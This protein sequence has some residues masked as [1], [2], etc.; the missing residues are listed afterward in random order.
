[1]IY[2]PKC[3][4]LWYILNTPR[5]I[6]LYCIIQRGFIYEFILPFICIVYL[7]FLSP[8]VFIND[9]FSMCIYY[10][11]S[12]IYLFM[13]YAPICIYLS[14]ISRHV[15]K[16]YTSTNM[17][18]WHTYLF[19]ILCSKQRIYYLYSNSIQSSRVKTNQTNKTNVNKT[20]ALLQTTEVKTNQTNTTNVNK[21]W[22]LLQTTEVKTNQTNTTNVNKT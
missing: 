11:C 10:L 9:V 12:K 1:M 16:M 21:T 22:A 15:F 4:H 17:Y 14:F 3:I 7:L 18:L 20:W 19:V 6:Y 5:C 8:R 13:I 2:I